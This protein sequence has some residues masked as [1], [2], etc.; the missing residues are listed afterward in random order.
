MAIDWVISEGKLSLL[1]MSEDGVLTPLIEFEDEVS[2]FEDASE[3]VSRHRNEILEICN[4]P[5]VD[6]SKIKGL[7]L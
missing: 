6:P 1:H 4:Q 3:L 2:D 5:G 7:D